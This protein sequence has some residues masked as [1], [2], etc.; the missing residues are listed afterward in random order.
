[1]TPVD[2]RPPWPYDPAEV[3]GP[4]KYEWEVM[5]DPDWQVPVA[6]WMYR[7]RAGAGPGHLACGEPGAARVNRWGRDDGR[8]WWAYC[9]D[10]MHAMGRWVQD[11][12]V[13]TW[14]PHRIGEG[15]PGEPGGRE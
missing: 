10:H 5:P 12:V 3:H 13:V 14:E 4:G 7:C 11:G 2:K 15:D 8:A 9:A 6:P 1:M